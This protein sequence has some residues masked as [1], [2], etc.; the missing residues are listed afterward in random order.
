MGNYN[1]FAN[2]YAEKT[3]GYE[4]EIESRNY[5]H[6]LLPSSLEGTKVLD[7]GCGSGQD[8]TYYAKKGAKVEGIDISE[9]EIEMA[10]K[11]NCGEFKVG[12]M[13]NLPYDSNTFDIVTSYYALQASDKVT[14]AIEEMIRVA[15]PGATILIIA[16]NPIRNLLEGWKNDGKMDYYKEGN[17]TSY[18]FDK[19][20]CRYW[21]RYN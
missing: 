15:K 13:K 10:N 8:A 3:A 20:L 18:I 19:S 7:V 21:H 12:D 4:V 6:S 9:K 1:K 17:V 14:K 16:K 11:L 2:E 5:Y